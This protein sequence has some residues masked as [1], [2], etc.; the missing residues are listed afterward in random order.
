MSDQQMLV[1]EDLE[2]DVIPSGAADAVIHPV[3]GVILVVVGLT[4]S[5][6]AH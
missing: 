5:S 3:L 4:W 1:I 2:F 6:P